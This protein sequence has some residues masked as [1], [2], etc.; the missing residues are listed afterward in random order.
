MMAS[1]GLKNFSTYVDFLPSRFHFP[2]SLTVKALPIYELKSA[3][4]RS[5]ASI[6]FSLESS[7]SFLFRVSSCEFSFH[8][9]GFMFDDLSN[10]V[11]LLFNS[12]LFRLYWSG[13]ILV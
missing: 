1:S 7:I 9:I 11:S 2:L 6:N 4:C 5:L 8:F 12:K 13:P 10:I 3:V